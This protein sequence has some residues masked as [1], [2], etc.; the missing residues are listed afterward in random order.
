MLG[1]VSGL[2]LGNSGYCPEFRVQGVG[3]RV[4]GSG[5]RVQGLGGLGFRA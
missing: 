5:F 3:F 1:M 2:W 4:Q